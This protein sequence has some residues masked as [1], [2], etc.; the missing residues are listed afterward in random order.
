MAGSEISLAQQC[1]HAQSRFHA[2]LVPR[3]P[4]F[5]FQLCICEFPIVYVW[6][7]V[8]DTL[9][10]HRLRVDRKLCIRLRT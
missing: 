2:I 5:I 6:T 9:E 10:D 4:R 8:N 3:R 1:T 7:G